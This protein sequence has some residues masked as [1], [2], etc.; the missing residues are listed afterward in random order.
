MAGL[1]SSEREPVA[2]TQVP[3]G[4]A[5][6]VIRNEWVRCLADL[7]E[8]RLMLVLT[9]GLSEQTLHELAELMVVEQRLDATD[10]DRE[11]DFCR[12]RLSEQYGYRW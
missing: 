7:V 1:S 5:R 12:K 8:R 2:G 10:V 11:I 3:R 6:W 9:E 4:F